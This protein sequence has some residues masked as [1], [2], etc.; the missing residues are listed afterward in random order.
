[1]LPSM[2]Q[3]ADAGLR[4]PFMADGLTAAP[5]RWTAGMEVAQ[6]SFGSANG[7]LFR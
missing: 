4:F 2:Q 6:I 5:P 7:G 3:M 1:M